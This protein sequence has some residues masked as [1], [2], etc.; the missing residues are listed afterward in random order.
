M[1]L[2]GLVLSLLDFLGLKTVHHTDN[3]IKKTT[4]YKLVDS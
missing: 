1:F 4:G 3:F 2:T